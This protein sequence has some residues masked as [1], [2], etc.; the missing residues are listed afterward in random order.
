MACSYDPYC[1]WMFEWTDCPHVLLNL[2]CPAD[3]PISTTPNHSTSPTSSIQPDSKCFKFAKEEELS[4]I[5]KGLVP[6]N[7]NNST[8]WALNNFDAWTKARNASYPDSPVPEDILMSSNPELLNLHL[9]RFVIE[10]RKANGEMYPPST[11][12]QLLC[13][14][15]RFIR[16]HNPECPNLSTIAKR[17]CLRGQIM[18]H[19]SLVPL[20]GQIMRF[21][22]CPLCS[23]VVVKEV[24]YIP[25]IISSRV[26]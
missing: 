24:G 10:T 11:L 20:K 22:N 7:T 21:I 14:I 4:E 1:L 26:P 8:K 25:S 13:G 16:E 15:L 12:H 2:P 19:I 9:S 5:A 6:E 3:P 17:C 23:I 18:S